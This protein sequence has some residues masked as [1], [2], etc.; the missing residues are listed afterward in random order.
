M[1]ETATSMLEVPQF[2]FTNLKYSSDLRYVNSAGVLNTWE[3]SSTSQPL[4]HLAS[5]VL[6]QGHILPIAPPASNS[7]WTVDFWGPALQCDDVLEADRDRIWVNMWNSF[8]LT[9]L[10]FPFRY[11]SWAPWSYA[12]YEL[13]YDNLGARG[14][15]R[16]SPYLLNVTN[17][18]QIMGPPPSSVSTEGALSIYVAVLPGSRGTSFFTSLGKRGVF[19][20]SSLSSCDWE[21]RQDLTE[22]L[23]SC[24]NSSALFV[25][26]TIFDGSTLLRCALH[27]ATYAADF[28]FSRDIQNI[29]ISRGPGPVV[30]GSRWF[31]YSLISVVAYCSC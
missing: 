8:N 17:G 30:N 24:S 31:R 14:I 16:N 22:P 23:T 5:A 26:A 19:Q 2:D 28:S 9:T 29:K 7:S 27:N 18:P 11:L 6:G 12:D 1:Q 4:Q 21:S 10:T 25:P 3:W 20:S 13:F 15:D